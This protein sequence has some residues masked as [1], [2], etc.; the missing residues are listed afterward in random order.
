MIPQNEDWAKLKEESYVSAKR[1]IR[2]AIKKDTK[3]DKELLRREMKKLPAGYELAR[4]DSDI[5]DKCLMNP[6]TVDFVSSFDSKDTL[7]CNPPVELCAPESIS[8][9]AGSKT[10]KPIWN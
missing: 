7:S 2:Y 5:Y 3:F 10:W 8:T 1:V 9:A 4:I 6:V